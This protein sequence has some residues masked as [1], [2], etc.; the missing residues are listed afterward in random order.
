MTLKPQM[1]QL[2]TETGMEVKYVKLHTTS[3]QTNQDL[4]TRI[5]T[6]VSFTDKCCVLKGMR[7]GERE[8][9]VYFS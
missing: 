5:K 8:S 1:K 3:P 4:Y 6:L 7:E 9:Q 2:C